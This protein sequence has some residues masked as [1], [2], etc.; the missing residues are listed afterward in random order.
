MPAGLI[1]AQLL[2][3]T[4]T[5]ATTPEQFAAWGWRLPFLFSIVLVVVGLVVRLSL[6]ESPVFAALRSEQARS[7]RPIVEVFRERPRELVLAALS[8]VANT[9][10]GYI[11]LAYLLAYGTAVLKLSRSFM[12]VVVIVGSVVWLVSIVVAARWSDRVGRK[13][14]YLVG[15][16]LLVVWAFPFF[17]LLDTAVPALIVLSVVVLTIGLGLSY[18]PQAAFFA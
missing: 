16:V 1:L 14:V 9:A 8:F 13:P 2:F 6:A 10:I 4:V 12:L 15:S 18:G 3:I 11:F 5:A 17:L 7:S